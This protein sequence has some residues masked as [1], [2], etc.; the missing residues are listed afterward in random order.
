MGSF[1]SADSTSFGVF[2]GYA[3]RSPQLFQMLTQDL[4]APELSEALND[5]DPS[6]AL[7]MLAQREFEDVFSLPFFSDTVAVQLRE[8]AAHSK[9]W[10]NQ[11]GLASPGLLLGARWYL[12]RADRRYDDLF[13]RL[14]VDVL[15]P[16]DAALFGVE[17]APLAH[18][19][20]YC[21]CYE[22][23]GDRALKAHT[24]DSDV[25]LNVLLGGNGGEPHAGSE[26]LLLDPTPE[27]TR[28]G[29]PRL[30]GFQGKSFQYRHESIGR[31]VVHPGD[32]WHAVEPLTGGSR[33]NLIT[34]AL[35]DD[36]SWKSTFY[37]EMESQL[38]KKAADTHL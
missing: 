35:R 15:R 4:L 26:L 23:S 1:Q 32:R 22:S 29:T 3:P 11:T 2:D 10:A 12:K 6:R 20:D 28:C 14:L 38:L 21:I 18:H 31:A 27:D 17:S 8:E 30:S 24:D 34:W 9:A 19:H 13:G 25:T 7:R 36:S 5:A 16:I 33:W 37:H